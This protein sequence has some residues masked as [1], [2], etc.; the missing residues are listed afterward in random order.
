MI[1]KIWNILWQCPNYSWYP[2]VH[3]W[4]LCPVADK[5]Y[6]GLPQVY[7]RDPGLRS[8]SGRWDI[9]Y[10]QQHQIRICRV[11]SGRRQIWDSSLW[12]WRVGSQPRSHSLDSGIWKKANLRSH[13]PGSGIW[14]EIPLSSATE[15]NLSFAFFQIP[16][17]RLAEWIW[18]L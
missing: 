14:V 2:T 5:W 9:W 10:A 1:K 6:S 4:Y 7:L 17:S 11:E 18:L 8:T 13:S 15:T 12:N 16:L 3:E